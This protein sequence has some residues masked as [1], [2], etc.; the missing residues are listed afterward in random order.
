MGMEEMLWLVSFLS[1][2]IVLW[3]DRYLAISPQVRELAEMARK[4]NEGVI[5]QMLWALKMIWI[6][7]SK[8]ALRFMEWYQL[9]SRLTASIIFT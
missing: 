4:D 2:E 1:I 7:N 8:R 6:S 3:S 9:P 5:K